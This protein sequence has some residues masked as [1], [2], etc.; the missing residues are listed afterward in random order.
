MKPEALSAERELDSRVADG[1][2]VRL[3]WNSVTDR[4]RVAVDDRKKGEAFEFE[5]DPAEAREAFIHPYAHA[6]RLAIEG[7]QLKPEVAV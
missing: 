3:L 4:L 2:Y 5:P 7:S 1:I 6:A